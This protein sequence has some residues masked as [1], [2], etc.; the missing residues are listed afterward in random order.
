MAEQKQIT[1]SSMELMLLIIII[2]MAVGMVGFLAYS[3][4]RGGI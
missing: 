1:L 3:Y 2:V 4:G